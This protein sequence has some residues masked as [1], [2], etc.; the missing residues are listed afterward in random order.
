M[1]RGYVLTA[2]LLI[3][4]I[5][6]VA[7]LYFYSVYRYAKTPFYQ[8]TSLRNSVVILV[9]PGVTLHSLTEQLR[10]AHVIS[11]KLKFTN[12]AQLMRADCHIVPGE[13]N[14]TP[15]MTPEKLIK[16]LIRGEIYLHR[17]TIIEGWTYKQMIHALENNNA[18]AKTLTNYEPETVMSALTVPNQKAEGQFYPDT[19]LFARGTHDI[20]LLKMAY[21]R[22]QRKL[23]QAWQIRAANLPYQ[24]PYEVLI[25]ASLI[26]KESHLEGERPKIAAVILKRLGI[27]MLLQID[28][29]VIYG[30]GEKYQGKLSKVSLN[31]KTPY[32]TYLNKGLPPTPIAMPSMSA[33][34]A[35]LHPE[36]SE[37]LYYV[38]NG[39]GGH[40]FSDNYKDHKLAV[41]QYWQYVREQQSRKLNNNRCLSIP[42]VFYLYATVLS[43]CHQN[44]PMWKYL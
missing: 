39:G 10:D 13:Y 18:I 9:P 30:L 19:Y 38:A 25:V 4:A 26:E 28:A 21:Q 41:A 23:N 34:N 7:L 36:Y 43:S 27:N 40:V 42:L 31:V 11:G 14:V 44:C 17:F 33:I 35:A 1:R 24:D 32:N 8:L 15:D 20:V 12:L 3:S 6:L 29:A 5:I 22:M 16:K 37:A 2:L